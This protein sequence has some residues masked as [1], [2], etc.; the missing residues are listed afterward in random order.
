MG[1]TLEKGPERGAASMRKAA[2]G[3]LLGHIIARLQVYRQQLAAG[4][5]Y[6]Y[7]SGER[8]FATYA[9]CPRQRL[10]SDFENAP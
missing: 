9:D 4:K 6:M 2:L 8:A 10:H 7:Q 3:A 5:L 1:K